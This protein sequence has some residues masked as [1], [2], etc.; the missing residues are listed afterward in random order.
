MIA[1]HTN[2]SS[3][4]TIPYTSQRLDDFRY[5]SD[6]DDYALGNFR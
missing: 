6:A 4:S 1:L 5:N 2:F 3:S